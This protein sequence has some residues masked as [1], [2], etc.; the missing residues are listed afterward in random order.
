[1]QMLKSKKGD[2]KPESQWRSELDEFWQWVD[3]QNKAIL[4]HRKPGHKFSKVALARTFK[5][6]ADAWERE[7][8]LLGLEPVQTETSVSWRGVFGGD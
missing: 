3:T 5:R 7:T 4:Q 1:M 8:R 6:P 2:I